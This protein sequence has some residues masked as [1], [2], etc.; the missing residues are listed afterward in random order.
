MAAFVIGPLLA[1]LA[2]AAAGPALPIAADAASFA[3]LAVAAA[4]VRGHPATAG[5]ADAGEPDRARGFAAITRSRPLAG[6]L[7]LTVVYFFLY[8]PVEVALPLYVTGPLRGSAALLGLF[9]TVFGIGAAA[10]SIIAG[11]TRRLPVWP[12]LVAAVIGWGA[13]LTPLGL[14]RLPVPAPGLLRRRRLALCAL[15]RPVSHLVPAGKLAR[16]AGRSSA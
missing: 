9:W 10:G 3:I 6:L 1:G 16:T 8:G 12:V 13:V 2:V 14:L 7:A 15:P 11:L 4:T 5:S